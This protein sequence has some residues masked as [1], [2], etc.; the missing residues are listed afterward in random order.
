MQKLNMYCITIHD[1]HLNLIKNLGYYPVGLGNT[2]KSKDF[3]RD[4][5]KTNICE[6]NP[7]YGEYTFYYWYWKNCLKDKKK[8]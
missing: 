1:R 2:I 7:F 4:N 3:L 8:K 5:T 6:K